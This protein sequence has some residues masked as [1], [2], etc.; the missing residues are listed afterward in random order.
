[1]EQSC[2]RE[3]NNMF[4]SQEVHCIL[5][6]PNF[7][8]TMKT[9]TASTRSQINPVLLFRIKSFF[10]ILFNISFYAKVFE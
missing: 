4:A 6:N 9:S 7:I 5:W 10:V 2:Y 8:T 3:A 1:M